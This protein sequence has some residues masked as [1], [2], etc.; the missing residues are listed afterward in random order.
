[1][2]IFVRGNEKGKDLIVLFCHMLITEGRV[3]RTQ[4]VGIVI[5]KW[6]LLISEVNKE[7]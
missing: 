4:P 5:C 6:K 2:R 3:I 1:M 7:Q